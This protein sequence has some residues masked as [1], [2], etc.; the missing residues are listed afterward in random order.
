MF[1]TIGEIMTSNYPTVSMEMPI[2]E[3]SHKLKRSGHHGFPVTDEEG[4]FY[5]MV[6]AS[7]VE[8]GLLKEN[9]DLKVSDIATR[10]PVTAYPDQSVHDILLRLGT[11]DVGRIPVVA[12]DDPLRLLG[13]LRRHDIIRG[14][15]KAA[16][17]AKKSGLA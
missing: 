13:V 10:N 5:G 3:L 15:S 4:H 6:T 8:E 2:I 9:P 7:D 11:I 1:V 14:Y 17:K 12:R 16:A